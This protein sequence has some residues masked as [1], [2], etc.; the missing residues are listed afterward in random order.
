MKEQSRVPFKWQL[1]PCGCLLFGETT[2]HRV[3][4]QPLTHESRSHFRVCDSVYVCVCVCW[5][6][7]HRLNLSGDD[8]PFSQAPAGIRVGGE[9]EVEEEEGI[10][11]VSQAE[12]KNGALTRCC[13]IEQNQTSED[14]SAPFTFWDHLGCNN[15]GETWITMATCAN[16]RKAV[17]PKKT[18][19]RKH[20]PEDKNTYRQTHLRHHL[21]WK[22]RKSFS[23]PDTMRIQNS[24]LTETSRESQQIHLL[25]I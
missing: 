17:H 25:D 8:V 18:K 5:C 20:L 7:C 1:N 14:H 13:S 21:R 3:R 22:R 11:S 15:L 6:V 12:K 16:K 4:L 24:G 9:R 23:D 10:H 2:F 19:Q